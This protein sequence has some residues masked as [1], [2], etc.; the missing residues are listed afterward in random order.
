VFG[1]KRWRPSPSGD[2]NSAHDSTFGMLA[3]LLPLAV[4]RLCG[5]AVERPNAASRVCDR[6]RFAQRLART[7]LFAELSGGLAAGAYGASKQR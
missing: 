7:E 4:Y 1:V 3:L 6:D 2:A 5:R